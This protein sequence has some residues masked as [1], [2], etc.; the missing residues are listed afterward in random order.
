VDRRYGPGVTCASSTGR[1]RI[2]RSRRRGPRLVRRAMLVILRAALGPMV[3]RPAYADTV[4][5]LPPTRANLHGQRPWGLRVSEGRH[6]T[7]AHACSGCELT[8]RRLS[9]TPS[10]RRRWLGEMRRAHCTS[11]RPAAVG[12][13]RDARASA[14]LRCFPL[15]NSRGRFSLAG[16]A[17]YRQRPRSRWRRGGSRPGTSVARV[18]GRDLVDDGIRLAELVARRSARRARARTRPRPT[19]GRRSR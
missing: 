1:D 16:P 10:G 8:A 3:L 7:Y 13:H 17:N 18:L 19:G 14:H 12:A 11:H 4:T 9:T 2:H 15:S 5:G 6:A